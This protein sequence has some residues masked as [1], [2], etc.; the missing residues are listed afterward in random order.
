MENIEEAAIHFG[1]RPGIEPDWDSLSQYITW[2]N[3]PKGSS[4]D[5]SIIRQKPIIS[6]SSV[7]SENSYILYK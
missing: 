6:P 1:Q 2:Q 5:K 4:Q 7:K 3:L